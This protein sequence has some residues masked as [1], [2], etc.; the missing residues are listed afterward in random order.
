MPM[1]GEIVGRILIVLLK[2]MMLIVILIFSKEFAVARD[3]LFKVTLL[4]TGTP[5][6]SAERFGYST[7]VEAGEQRLV[8]DFGRGVAIRLAQL[9]V[10]LGSINAHFLTHF[11]SDHTNG[12]PDL[13]LTGWLRP[14][15]GQRNQPFLIYGPKGLRELTSGLTAA[16]ARDIAMRVEDE[17]SPLSGV[18][19][20]AHEIEAGV[21]YEKE[22]LRVSAFDNDHGDKVKPSLGYKIQYKGKTIVLSG[23]TKYSE[24]VI[25]QSTNADL[26]VHC[27]TV[28]PPDLLR[29]FP[30]YQAVYDHLSSPEQAAKVFNAASPKQ[31]VFSHI[32]LNGN[33]TIEDLLARTR[34]IYSG[35]LKVGEDLMVFDLSP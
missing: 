18:T 13:W 1:S 8:F 3:D 27:V 24:E 33:S 10:P 16:Y 35:P 9:K 22:G 25:K 30:Q 29:Q 2:R 14:P 11:H 4:G 17:K 15:Y 31:V 34:A 5:V 21:V 19:F 26:L 20:D 28:I 7:L 6:P 32:G 23:D 12:L